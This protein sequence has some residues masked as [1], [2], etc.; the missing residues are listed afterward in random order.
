MRIPRRTSR[1]ASSRW[2]L[3]RAK[4]HHVVVLVLGVLIGAAMGLIDVP[5]FGRSAQDGI[6]QVNSDVR[7]AARVI[8][9]DT[10]DVNGARS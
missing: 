4:P 10:I 1:R 2:L 5:L 9:G 6:A 3:G 7:G 8:D